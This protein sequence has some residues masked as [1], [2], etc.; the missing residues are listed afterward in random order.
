MTGAAIV[1]VSKVIEQI[2][3]ALEVERK[4]RGA[5]VAIGEQWMLRQN[6]GCELTDEERIL[7]EHL[8]RHW[9]SASRALDQLLEQPLRQLS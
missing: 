1:K 5:V 6:A 8:V 9:R 3:T 2:D 4:A 7:H